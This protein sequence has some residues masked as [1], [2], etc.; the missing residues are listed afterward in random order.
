MHDLLDYGLFTNKLEQAFS[1]CSY[2]PVKSVVTLN[3][4]LLFSR[5]KF[6]KSIL[7]QQRAIFVFNKIKCFANTYIYSE[8]YGVCDGYE[9]FHY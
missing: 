7:M 4:V 9:T 1:Y 8:L 5:Y 6:L 2:S 3:Y